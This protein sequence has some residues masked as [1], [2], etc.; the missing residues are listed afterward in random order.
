[1]V[2]HNTECDHHL[3]AWKNY[4]RKTASHPVPTFKFPTTHSTSTTAAPETTTMEHITK[5]FQ[6]FMTPITSTNKAIITESTIMSTTDTNIIN[7]TFNDTVGQT[8][9]GGATAN[10]TAIF[11]ISESTT[12]SSMIEIMQNGSLPILPLDITQNSSAI[13]E[14]MDN[15][16]ILTTISE[17]ASSTADNTAAIVTST[18]EKVVTFVTETVNQISS[19]ESNDK[20]ASHYHSHGGSH[21]LLYVILIIIIAILILIGVILLLIYIRYRKNSFRA[22]HNYYQVSPM[23]EKTPSDNG[24]EEQKE[25]PTEMYMHYQC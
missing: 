20:D 17:F 21:H 15:S 1:M 8:F 13:T 24:Q 25:V 10:S 4:S 16:T 18:T 23:K 3:C 7:A 9:D 5:F 12:S 6:D 14:T 2:Y 22:L 11:N 19:T